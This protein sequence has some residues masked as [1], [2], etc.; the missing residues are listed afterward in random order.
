MD[1]SLITNF[2]KLKSYKNKIIIFLLN[3]LGIVIVGY[4]ALKISIYFLTPNQ[5]KDPIKD[6][7][8]HSKI[9]Y[10]LSLSLSENEK[11]KKYL[12]IQNLEVLR[13]LLNQFLLPNENIKIELY[14]SNFVKLIDI[15]SYKESDKG[16]FKVVKDLSLQKVLSAG[17]GGY[18]LKPGEYGF[19][20]SGINPVYYN[21]QIIGLIEVK[22]IYDGPVIIP[23]IYKELI[24]YAP[25]KDI[26]NYIVINS[27]YD[28]KLLKEL[29][30]KK[31]IFK[32]G[33]YILL[34][35]YKDYFF[36]YEIDL[37]K[38]LI[39]FLSTYIFFA[40]LY[41]ILVWKYLFRKQVGTINISKLSKKLEPVPYI[42][43]SED[44][45]ILAMNQDQW[46]NYIG[47][48]KKLRTI[49][50]FLKKLDLKDSI[51]FYENHFKNLNS[52]KEIPLKIKD[53]IVKLKIYP[54]FNNIKILFLED[55][56]NVY[57]CIS[58]LKQEKSQLEDL[59]NE[60]KLLLK[61]KNSKIA[62]LKLQLYFLKKNKDKENNK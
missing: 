40:I 41:L 6:Y 1:I 51:R 16:L 50:D 53:R 12:H 11:I 49:F 56:T 3:F 57:K 54:I 32:S 47:S 20:F 8:F 38:F 29:I 22:Q 31:K 45:Q 44:G 9:F 52:Y 17:V 39:V 59:I 2:F 23:K 7:L 42:I 5:Y 27:N 13:A 14:N 35:K 60:L 15:P 26:G 24:K 34:K 30:E 55:L 62:E 46:K 43:F 10:K 33:K 4:F 48:S 25:I 19:E 28:T 18:F 58:K 61:T 37:T 21:N 36:V